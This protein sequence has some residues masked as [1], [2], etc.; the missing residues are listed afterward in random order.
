MSDTPKAGVPLREVPRLTEE[1]RRRAEDNPAFARARGDLINNIRSNARAEPSSPE[2]LAKVL[3]M[4]SMLQ[5]SARDKLIERKQDERAA[6][7]LEPF[8]PPYG[9]SEPSQRVA[10]ASTLAP[11]ERERRDDATLGVEIAREATA[12]TNFTFRPAAQ[13]SKR[14]LFVHTSRDGE[15]VKVELAWEQFSQ[16]AG[17]SIT[18][19]EKSLDFDVSATATE[20]NKARDLMSRLREFRVV[21]LRNSDVWDDLCAVYALVSDDDQFFKVLANPMN[22]LPFFTEGSMFPELKNM[23]R[24]A[25]IDD[26]CDA[27]ATNK[28]LIQRAYPN[29]PNAAVLQRIYKCVAERLI[30]REDGD[31]SGGAPQNRIGH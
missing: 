12:P 11:T 8:K 7:V 17:G 28:G 20:K 31:G 13:E 21:V 27:T 18:L 22:V 16:R 29:A 19:A 15:R 26:L 9:Y 1:Q 5:L 23:D 3:A 30:A 24:E 25:T 4:G 10:E 6:Q 14:H 2:M